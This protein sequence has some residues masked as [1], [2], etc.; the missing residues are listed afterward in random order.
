MQYCA[1]CG[2]ELSSEVRFC[3]Q[4]GIAVGST[5]VVGVAS[6][7]NQGELDQR[8]SGTKKTSKPIKHRKLI[9]VGSMVFAATLFI[10]AV[11]S[12]GE[13]DKASDE[14][15]Q[16][17]TSIN[18]YSDEHTTRTYEITEMGVKMCKHV[19][20]TP[21]PHRNFEETPDIEMYNQCMAS[22]E[23]F[24]KR[25][26]DQYEIREYDSLGGLKSICVETL[27]YYPT[28]IGQPIDMGSYN[29]CLENT[30]KEVVRKRNEEMKKAD[31]EFR[32][33]SK[34]FLEDFAKLETVGEYKIIPKDFTSRDPSCANHYTEA[35]EQIRELD[36][37]YKSQEL[38]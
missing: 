11:I 36:Q 18:D 2:K 8:S 9:I 24:D 26:L 17:Y 3:P 16:K 15:T 27:L 25:Q 7:E 1:S 21:H 31:E 30:E 32:R 10:W 14:Y 37:I 19:Y 38:K 20:I 12:S 33:C 22:M 4:C 28:A 23:T 34:I 29:R 5:G 35:I 13:A 6:G